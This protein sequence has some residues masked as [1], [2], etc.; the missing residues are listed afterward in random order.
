L[1]PT[2]GLWTWRPLKKVYL[3][4]HVPLTV[5]KLVGKTEIV[6][7]NVLGSPQDT[8]RFNRI[9][10]IYFPSLRALQTCAASPGAKEALDHAAKI[11]TGGPPLIMIA[12]E[13]TFTFESYASL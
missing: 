10:E 12:E 1:W 9:A 2:H 13:E 5:A 6:T 4:E 8:R 3:E 7:T 11:S